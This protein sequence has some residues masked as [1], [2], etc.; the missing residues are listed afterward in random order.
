MEQASDKHIEKV[1]IGEELELEGKVF[2]R[3]IAQHL[4]GESLS[5]DVNESGLTFFVQITGMT[6][7][8][9]AIGFGKTYTIVN[10]M[11]DGGQIIIHPGATDKIIGIG[12]T[13]VDHGNMTNTTATAKRGDYVVL[14]SDGDL[15]W[16]VQECC[17]IWV[18]AEA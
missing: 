1:R 18:I 17:G 13:G 7:T 4:V 6:I 10:D 9:P 15:G 8:L 14:V 3:E 12:Y 2:H 5:I 11:P 16:Y